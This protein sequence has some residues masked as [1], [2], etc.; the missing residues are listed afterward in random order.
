MCQSR[1]SLRKINDDNNHNM[2]GKGCSQ[3]SNRKEKKS[4]AEM[5]PLDGWRATPKTEKNRPRCL[6]GDVQY[7]MKTPPVNKANNVFSFRTLTNRGEKGIE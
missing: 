1:G 5:L 6:K 7:D 3:R 4:V 2:Y